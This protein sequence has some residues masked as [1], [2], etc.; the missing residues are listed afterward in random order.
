M[1]KR[2]NIGKMQEV[3]DFPNLVEIQTDSYTQFL[4]LGVP[5]AKRKDSGLQAVF[6]EVFPIESYDGTYKLEYVSYAL[7]EA[8]YSLEECFKRSL[9]YASSLKVKMRLKGP[10]ETKEQDVYMGELPLMTP[11][12][13]FVVN[14]DERVVVSQ[15]HRSP[16]VSYE[17]TIHPNGKILNSARVIPD[18]GAWLEFEF[19]I[20]DILHAYIDR[21]RK[22][23]AT[24]LLRVFGFSTDKE[25]IDAFCGIEKI[26]SINRYH[27]K[28]LVGHTI[29]EDILDPESQM[30]IAEKG[31]VLSKE[32]LSK[33]NDKSIIVPKKKTSDDD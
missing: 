29:A 24:T 12:G 25:I 13:T 11:T 21:R 1:S 5:K 23:L 8:K 18:R 31:T 4:Q 32:I 2:L 19:D 16:G 26:D 27:P 14:G 22:I 7:S 6:R 9:T 15:L 33:L 10:K 17:K 30:V 28:N 3:A 20:N